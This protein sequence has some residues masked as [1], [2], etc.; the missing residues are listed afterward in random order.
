MNLW[1]L[2]LL[3]LHSFHY[4][5][6][7]YL[8]KSVSQERVTIRIEWNYITFIKCKRHKNDKCA[9][10]FQ[11]EPKRRQYD[12]DSL[13]PLLYNLHKFF[14]YQFKILQP[15][16]LKYFTKTYEN[17]QQIKRCRSLGKDRKCTY[18]VTI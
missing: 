10:L 12:C 14:K 3:F 6:F 8:F 1:I 13:S 18:N 7:H 11:N 9:V 17:I 5:Q 2:G 4:S 15:T 16:K